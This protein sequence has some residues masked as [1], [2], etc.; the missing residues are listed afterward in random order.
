MRVERHGDLLSRRS[1]PATWAVAAALVLGNFV[2][3]K[4]ISDVCDALF[5]RIGRTAYEWVMLGG[6]AA[7]SLA[8][9]ALV[10]R[11]GAP[12]LRH[13][14][15]LAALLG[16]A[17]L[18]I[19]AQQNLLV[20]NV[21]LIHLPQ[22]GLLAALLAAAGLPPQLAWW[23]ATLAGALDETY[24]WRVIYAGVPNTYFDWND[25][26]LNALGAAW[27]V[28]LVRGG[29]PDTATAGER[30]AQRLLLLALLIGLPLALALAP[31]ALTPR[32]GFPYWGPALRRAL[33]G[34]DYHVMPAAEGVGS[35]LAVWALVAL[36]CSA[37]RRAALPLAAAA[38]LLLPGCVPRRP[39]AL[40]PPAPRPFF[41]TFWCGP[42]LAE[43]SDARAA[44]IASA[45]FDVIGPPCEGRITPTL[46]RQ[47]LDVAA[48]HGLKAWIKDDRVDQL[49]GLRPDWRAGVDA[50]V[51]EVG[52]H[53]ALDGYFLVDEPGRDQF[54]DLGLIVAR[55]RQADPT[56]VPYVNLL[57]DYL[58]SEAL[59]TDTY[60]EHLDAFMAEVQ[61]SLLSLDYYP[62]LEGGDRDTFFVDLAMV[63][64]RA[65]AAGIPWLLIVQAMPH[66]GYRDPTPGELS[67]QVFNGMAFGA[68]AISYFTYWTPVNVPHADRWQFRRGLV[69]HGV[70]TD[71]LA[72]VGA[73]NHAA[74]AIARQLAG[75]T[76]AAVLDG[77]GRFGDALPAP[78]L[79]GID[80]AATVGLFAAADGRRA[81][82]L[83]NRDYRAAGTVRLLTLPA[84]PPATAFDPTSG[85]WHPAP[86]LRFTLPP[87]GA[88]LVQWPAST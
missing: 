42:P 80:G 38:L 21:E 48:R 61:P 8:A 74:H 51:G 63:R 2:L 26:V 34:Y 65:R 23:V 28:V 22:F 47:A 3:H 75:F 14:R 84:T 71:K 70:A 54:P 45:G 73:I 64:E 37:P 62:F 29:R 79:R 68:G 67:W 59:G 36:A 31:P 82:L 46:T 72:A 43:L 49:D 11:G 81:A 56:R 66:G 15:S 52:G 35:L 69:E 18:T 41:I 6:I 44:E 85:R 32:E 40:P 27:A 16:L 53:P 50:V 87:G 58:G 5:A 1:H 33:T 77:E 12:A 76:S 9:A 24:Q 25:I 83:V 39:P 78:P 60:A 10:L 17:A 20:S 7:L 88:Q 4:P 57:P 13:P 55:L 86:D 19:C 30:R